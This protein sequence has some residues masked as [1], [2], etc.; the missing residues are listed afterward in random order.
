MK[1]IISD[2]YKDRLNGGLA[3]S[4]K[5]SDFDQVQLDKGTKVEFEHTDDRKKA[6]EI[7]M[8]HLTEDS[9]YYKKLEVME[10]E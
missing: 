8:D 7:A 9:D 2:S 6:R 5:P 4:K 1:T 3:D 10:S